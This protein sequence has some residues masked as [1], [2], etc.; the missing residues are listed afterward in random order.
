MARDL[1]NSG[2]KTKD[3]IW[4]LPL[5]KPYQSMLSSQIAD[6]QNSVDSPFG[7]AITA[8]LYLQMFV[9]KDTPWVHFDVMAWNIRKLPGRP[10]G[11]EAFGIRAVFD[12]L[13]T[14]YSK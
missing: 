10:I 12:Y 11:G 1:N 5:F 8:A 6:T 13:Q 14:K 9:S 2:Q 4:Q 7:G 3:P